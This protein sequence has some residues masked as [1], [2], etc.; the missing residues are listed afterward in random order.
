[1]KSILG[2]LAISAVLATPVMAA[3]LRPRPMPVKAPP[4][5]VVVLYNWTGCYIGGHVGWAWGDKKVSDEYGIEVPAYN[6]DVDGFLVGGQ[7]GCNWQTDR[8]VFG[9]EGQ[10]SWADLEGSSG[11]DYNG[12]AFRTDG[13]IIGSFAGRIGYAFGAT[14]QTLVFVKGGLAFVHERF[15][16]G[17]PGYEYLSSKDLRWGWMIGGG[18]EQALGGNWSVKAEYNFNDFGKD[19]HDLCYNG[20]CYIYELKQHVHVVKFGLNYRFGGGAVV[21]RY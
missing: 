5:P 19:S 2:A 6:H 16:V 21:A 8:W 1:M 10:A 4:P 11:A 15:G 13:D 20:S 17:Y 18:I 12:D 14:G 9:I 3:D 7:V